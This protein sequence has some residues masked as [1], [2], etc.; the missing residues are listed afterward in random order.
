MS[1]SLG[2]QLN[3]NPLAQSFYIEE[4]S[5]IFLTK[6]DLFFKTRD[7]TS[8][9]CLQIRPMYNGMPSTSEIIPQSV[10]YVNGSNVNVSDDVTAA[11]S[12]SAAYF[13][14][15]HAGSMWK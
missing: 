12:W 7:T 11:T 5:G 9:V 8:P 10:V 3:R 1:T 2:Y 6:V 15:H 14:D 4:P 13:P